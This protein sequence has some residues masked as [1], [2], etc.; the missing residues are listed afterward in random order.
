MASLYA[1]AIDAKCI[2]NSSPLG[3][4][5]KGKIL[6][7]PLTCRMKFHSRDHTILL[8]IVCFKFKP[9]QKNVIMRTSLFIPLR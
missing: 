5:H 3:D 8:Y 9:N 4:I 1:T 2:M 7:Q 6:R